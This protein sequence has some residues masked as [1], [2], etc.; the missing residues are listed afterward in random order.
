V[1]ECLDGASRS[2]VPPSPQT[3]P[4]PL[5]TNPTIRNSDPSTEEGTDES[6]IPS[7][8]RTVPPQPSQELPQ[9]GDPNEISSC[10][11]AHNFSVYPSG[12]SD[13]KD[14]ETGMISPDGSDSE[15][16]AGTL[17]RVS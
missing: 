3:M 13:Y 7:P 9:K 8:S 2:W 4:T 11:F 14:L 6:E 15:E 16:S 12:A 5:I 1:L 10:F 17:D